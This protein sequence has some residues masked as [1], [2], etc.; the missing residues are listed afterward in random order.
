V[1]AI[2]AVRREAAYWR[3]T[4][5]A[6][7]PRAYWTYLQTCPK[8]PHIADARRHLTVLSAEFQPPPDFRPETFADLPAASR[9]T[10]L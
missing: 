1:P 9:R 6:S 8:G 7:T 4:V 3:R 5:D 10:V 2:L